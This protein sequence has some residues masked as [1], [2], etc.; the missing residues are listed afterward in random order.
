MKSK[1]FTLV[2]LMVTIAVLAVIATLAVPSFTS[3]IRKNQLHSEMQDFVAL[4]KE[5]RADAILKKPR[6]P[7]RSV[8]RTVG[9][10]AMEF[11]GMLLIN[12]KMRLALPSWVTGLSMMMKTLIIQSV[13]CW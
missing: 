3:T 11:S 5:T 6:T 4:L 9:R 2:E 12:L 7:L 8:G 10:L 13:L 1:G